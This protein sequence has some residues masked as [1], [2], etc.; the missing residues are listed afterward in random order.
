MGKNNDV[1]QKR[2]ES[3]IDFF[4]L[5]AEIKRKIAKLYPEEQASNDI[6][7]KIDYYDEIFRTTNEFKEGFIKVFK[8]LGMERCIEELNQFFESLNK[9]GIYKINNPKLLYNDVVS[10]IRREFLEKVKEQ[11]GYSGG[12]NLEELISKAK[13]INELLHCIHS[14]IVN[15]GELLQSMPSIRSKTNISNYSITL[16]GKENDLA[17]KIFDDFPFELNTQETTIV[18][19]DDRVLMMVRGVGHELT[20]EIEPSI[21]GKCMFRYFVPK[22]CNE[23]MIMRLKGIDRITTNGVVGQF[24]ITLNELTSELYDFISKVPDDSKRVLDENPPN[25]II[26]D[27]GDQFTVKGTENKALQ[28]RLVEW[29]MGTPVYKI[30]IIRRWVAKSIQ[31]QLLTEGTENKPCKMPQE[32]IPGIR[33]EDGTPYPIEYPTTKRVEIGESK[34]KQESRGLQ[35]V[36]K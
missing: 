1:E 36:E 19:L 27:I 18:S 16:Y 35:H 8:G 20:I 5:D 24:E 23:E 2:L 4:A 11:T 17:R 26:N 10:N 3:L 33:K 12:G 25:S 32:A 28:Q 13:T 15:N 34:N 31:N 7:S 30:G 22:I 14:H 29:I 9:A 21:E 6:D